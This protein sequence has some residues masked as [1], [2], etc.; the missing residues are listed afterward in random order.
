MAEGVFPLNLNDHKDGD[1]YQFT[2]VTLGGCWGERNYPDHP[3]WNNWGGF[4]LLWGAKG[5][6]FG[7]LT[8]KI[9]GGKKNEETGEIEGATIVC[10]SECMGKQFVK[11]ALAAF[12]ERVMLK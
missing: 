2:E 10:D 11:E 7:E 3:E 12:A 5:V 1:P 6:G 9:V 4:V 8:F